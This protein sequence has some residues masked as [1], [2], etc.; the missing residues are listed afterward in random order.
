MDVKQKSLIQ[1]GEPVLGS[2]YGKEEVI[3]V[4]RLL[5]ESMD[6]STG[7]FDGKEIKCFETDFL[8]LCNC[9]YAVALNGAGVALDLA[10][11]ALNIEPGDEIISC[12]INFPGTHLVIIGS[13]AKLVL[14]EPDPMTLNINPYDVEKRLSEKTRAIIV[15]HMNGLAAE[16]DWLKEIVNNYKYF[17]KEKPKIIC[18][19]ARACGTTYKG[20]HVGRGVWATIFSFDSKKT[21]TTLGKGGMVVTDDR[22]LSDKLQNS[23]SNYKITEIQAAVGRVQL[24]KLKKMV[25]LRRVLAEE[26]HRAFSLFPQI[27]IQKDSVNSRNSYYLYTM[28][29]PENS[30][31]IKRDKLINILKDDYGIGCAVGNPPTY[32]NN[33]LI[34]I[35][36]KGQNLPL[37]DSLG[38]R[39]LCLCIH[40]AITKT[41][42]D[43]I[44]NAFIK[45]FET[46][47]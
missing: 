47:F 5:K 13:G 23:G 10:L 40:P 28:I 17:K 16:I 2:I 15:T 33:K 45:S 42:N 25:N 4:N 29:L 34:K 19:A 27:N 37:S 41:T 11:K 39:I 43:Y 3:T 6:P 46:I 30:R 8:S 36:T 14:C 9:K 44:I 18:D 32:K 12:A 38:N 1:K 21:I 26:R 22:E 35:S 7:F 20:H 31:G 24:K